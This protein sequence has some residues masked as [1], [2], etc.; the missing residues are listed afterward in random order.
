[1]SRI[2]F[3]ALD[4]VGDEIMATLELDIDVGPGRIRLLSE[5]HELVIQT[6]PSNEKRGSHE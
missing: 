1:M 5:F 4:H 2:S 6:D 3:Y